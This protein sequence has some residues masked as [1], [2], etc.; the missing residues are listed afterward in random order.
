MWSSV[1]MVGCG[2]TRKKTGRSPTRQMATAGSAARSHSPSE[3]ISNTRVA[4]VSQP[5]G[6]VIRVM[7]SSFMMS[8]KVKRHGG[9]Q[10]DAQHRQMHPLQAPPAGDAEALR[11]LVDRHR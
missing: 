11:R 9:E 1:S 6:R 8:T 3:V 10:R 4:R 2:F 7:G 5:N